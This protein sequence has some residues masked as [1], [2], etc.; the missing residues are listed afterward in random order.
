M[1]RINNEKIQ[2]SYNRGMNVLDYDPETGTSNFAV[3]LKLLFGYFLKSLH[4]KV[5]GLCFFL[6]TG[7]RSWLFGIVSLFSSVLSA[8]EASA[9]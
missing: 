8:S 2:V 5:D 3:Y 4:L 9:E 6:K 7:E 1:F